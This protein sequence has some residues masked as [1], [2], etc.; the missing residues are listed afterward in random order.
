MSGWARSGIRRPVDADRL[1]AEHARAHHGLVT[2]R[3]LRRAG[4][5]DW[6]IDYR[7]AHGLLVPVEPGIFRVGGS[8]TTDMQETLAAVL[9]VGSRA[10]A[11][12]QTAVWLW[13]IWDKRPRPTHVTTKF[14]HWRSKSYVVHRSSDFYDEYTAEVSGIPVTTME[15]TIVDLG[16][17]AKLGVVAQVLDSALRRKLVAIDG[18]SSVVED[19]AR[20]GR[21]GIRTARLLVEE[22]RRWLATTESELEDLFARVVRSGGLPEPVEQ[23][24]I[25]DRFGSFIGRVDFFYP[26]QS[27]AIELD[28]FAFHSDPES[29]SGDRVRQNR[30]VM[31]GITLLRYTVRDLRERREGVLLELERTLAARPPILVTASWTT[32]S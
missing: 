14:S 16:A 31:E 26:E 1:I 7:V 4:L 20:Q 3:E 18:V 30:L 25:H 22:R 29:F 13:G 21:S 12:H 23:V 32:S 10:A 27:V 11:S 6:V 19:L 5:G 2:R 8:P 9:G 28:G 15:R 17:T 24:D